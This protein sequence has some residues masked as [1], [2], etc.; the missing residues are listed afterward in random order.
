MTYNDSLAYLESLNTF[1]IKLGLSR[2]ERLAELLGHPERRYKTIHVTGTNGKGSV[3]CMTA[4]ILQKSGLRT[5][6]YT[7]PHLFSYTERFKIN[8]EEI[9]ESDFA[10]CIDRVKKAVEQMISEGEE[11]PTQFEVLT[12]L[13]FLWFAEQKVDY[14]VIEVGLGGL[15]DSTNIITPVLSVITNVT[16]EHAD[17]CDGTLDGVA[18]HKAGIIKNGVPVITAAEGMPLEIIRRTAEEKGAELFVRGLDFT[19]DFV[20]FHES[21]QELT[22]SSENLGVRSLHYDLSLLG[23]YQI[24][25]SSL[26]VMAAVLLSRSEPSIT[27]AAMQAAL[28]NAVWPGRFEDMSIGNQQIRVDGAHNPAGIKALREALDRYYPDMPRV[29]LMGILKDKAIDEM[30]EALLRPEDT[31]VATLPDSPRAAEPEL[32]VEKAA[33]SHG[34]A[35]ADNVKALD[36]ALELSGE[37]TLLVCAGSLYLIG[38]LRQ[39]LLQK[40]H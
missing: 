26:A 5:G 30:L 31:L 25:N 9:S 23:D 18:R 20:R 14:A 11:S 7:S 38:G 19:S 10:D 17:R 24:A 13:A 29:F 22:L 12:A 15:L 35:E 2:I 40:E 4:E 1:G 3:S 16:L 28:K 27:P 6:L 39:L 32:L 34:E 37:G 36:R 21:V 33:V 8:G